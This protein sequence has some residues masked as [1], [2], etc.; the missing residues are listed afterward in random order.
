MLWHGTVAKED[1]AMFHFSPTWHNLRPL[2]LIRVSSSLMVFQ[3]LCLERQN[4]PF[5]SVQ[6]ES[7]ALVRVA[8]CREAALL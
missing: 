3:L 4:S 2:S 7:L 8:S 1:P 5:L 6:T